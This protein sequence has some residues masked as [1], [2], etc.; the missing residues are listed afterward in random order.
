MYVKSNY[1]VYLKKCKCSTFRLYY[2]LFPR[3]KMWAVS[4]PNGTP[5]QTQRTAFDEPE[6]PWSKVVYYID[7]I[8][9]TPNSLK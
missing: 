8:W 5:F 1:L 6:V 9:D 2:G 4:H 7:S 3:V